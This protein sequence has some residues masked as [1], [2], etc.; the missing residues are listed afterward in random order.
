MIRKKISFSVVIPFFKNKKGLESILFLLSNQT[1][2]ADEII[3]VDDSSPENIVEIT[4][5]YKVKYVRLEKNSGVAVARNKGLELS[6]SDVTVFIDADA[7]PD[8]SLIESFSEIYEKYWNDVVGVGGRA[9]E[10]RVKNSSD[11]WRARHLSQ[12]YGEFE[13]LKIPFLFGVCCS[14]KTNLLKK[15]GGFDSY[16]SSNVGEDYDLGIRITKMGLRIAYS[17]NIIVNHQRMDD[18]RSLINS[19]YLWSFWGYLAQQKNGL[20][21]INP[22]LGHLYR[23]IKFTFEDFFTKNGFNL[24]SLGVKI[25]INKFKGLNEARKLSK[26]N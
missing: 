12:D 22:W 13:N 18:E 6:N 25:F 23:F 2:K 14:Y 10:S 1:Q 21:R 20:S 11:I 17:P 7:H 26:I 9:F 8:L 24:V 5:K 19:Q 4:N 15:I 3:V 16:Y